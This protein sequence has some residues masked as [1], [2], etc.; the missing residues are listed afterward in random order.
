MTQAEFRALF[1]PATNRRLYFNHAAVSPLA[2]PV[3]EAMNAHLARRREGSP[4]TWTKAWEA[5]QSL[6]DLYAQLVHTT[7]DRIALMPNTATGLNILASGLSW[8][9]G[10]RILLN[11]HEFPANVIPFRNLERLGV[12][13]DFVKSEN[14]ALPVEAFEKAIT[15]R[16]KI[17][18]ISIVQYMT[19]FRADVKVLAELCHRHNIIFSV[20]A[21]QALGVLPVDVS[22]GIDFLATGGHKWLQSPLGSGFLFITREL[23]DRIQQ[24]H[25]G[26][27]SL[28]HP[29]KFSDFTQPISEEARRYELG[30]FNAVNC[31]GAREAVALLLAADQKVVFQHVRGLVRHF[32]ERLSETNF[33][34]VFDFAEANSSGIFIFT[35]RDSSLNQAMLKAITARDVVISLRDMGLRLSPHYYNTIAEIDAIIDILKEI[36]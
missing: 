19:G 36:G 6:R 8:E 31:V 22:D 18:S 35:H 7:P 20:D 9:K 2:D 12:E 14:G 24:A 10:D 26:Y 32:S 4:E 11:E 34:P 1:T 23:Q 21:I 5:A 15:P 29:E 13:L 3:L 16:T 25:L 27:M 33:R 17:L 30:A 28:E